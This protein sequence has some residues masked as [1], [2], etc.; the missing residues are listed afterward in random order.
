M[1]DV[2]LTLYGIN[3]GLKDGS[4]G[5]GFTQE[6]LIPHVKIPMFAKRILSYFSMRGLDKRKFAFWVV[7][8]E[9]VKHGIVKL[10]KRC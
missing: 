4:L 8:L 10:V 3:C 7:S 6:T 5:L 9:V 2:S 1:C